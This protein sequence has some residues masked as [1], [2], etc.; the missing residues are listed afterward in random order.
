[1]AAVRPSGPQVDDEPAFDRDRDRRTNLAVVA[2]IPGQRAAHRGKALI[3]PAADLG[4]GGHGRHSSDAPGPW[5]YPPVAR[6][7]LEVERYHCLASGRSLPSRR[8]QAQLARGGA[9]GGGD[10]RGLPARALPSRA[11]RR[12][13]AARGD[14][15]RNAAFPPGW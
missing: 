8:E 2:E 11:Q 13:R 3:A 15:A 12:A 1:A 6:A 5:Y 7:D 10:R 14:A 9:G 4:D